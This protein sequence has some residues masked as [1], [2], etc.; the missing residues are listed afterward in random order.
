MTEIIEMVQTLLKMHTDAY[1]KC[2]YT[3]LAGSMEQQCAEDFVSKLFS[4]TDSQR[5]LL[6]ETKKRGATIG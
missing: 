6:I 3:L 1:L 5:P 2:K 4:L